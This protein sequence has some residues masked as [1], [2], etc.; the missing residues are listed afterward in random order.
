MY[1]SYGDILK[2]YFCTYI[3]IVH[4]YDIYIY[5]MITLYTGNSFPVPF[6][7]LIYYT[8]LRTALYR[9]PYRMSHESTPT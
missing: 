2:L 7:V 6:A 8:T 5:M 4:I 9:I 3:Y 1:V